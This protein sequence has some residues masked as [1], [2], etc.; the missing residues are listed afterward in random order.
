MDIK[1]LEKMASL[2][3]K[4][5]RDEAAKQWDEWQTEK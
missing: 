1:N 5:L 4:L 2:G 3:K